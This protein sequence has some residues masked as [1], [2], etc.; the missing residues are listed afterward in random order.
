MW[1][2]CERSPFMHIFKFH[3]V[4]SCKKIYLRNKWE[5]WSV[6][7]IVSY[8][9]DNLIIFERLNWPSLVQVWQQ[10]RGTTRLCASSLHCHKNMRRKFLLLFQ[11]A[12]VADAVTQ[13]TGGLRLVDVSEIR[14]HYCLWFHVELVSA[15]SSASIL[16]Q[17]RSVMGQGRIKELRIGWGWTQ[18]N[19]K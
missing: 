17:D 9:S 14:N 11:L 15:S 19:S 13:A 3:L 2:M 10:N 6:N 8:S 18:S 1:R 16:V 4:T 7:Y 5:A 12:F